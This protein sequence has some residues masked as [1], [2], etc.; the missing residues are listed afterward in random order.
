MIKNNK[1]QKKIKAC[2]RKRTK[3]RNKKG[4]LKAKAVFFDAIF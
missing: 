1:V 4:R 2:K 3:A